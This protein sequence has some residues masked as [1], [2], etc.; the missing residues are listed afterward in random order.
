MR[1]KIEWQWEILDENPASAT[2][3][4]KV[5]GGW[6]LVHQTYYDLGTQKARLC[7]SMTFIA[8]RD[9]EWHVIPALQEVKPNVIAADFEPKAFK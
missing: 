7:E 5:I 3:R 4:A 1:K 8:D 9:H 6:V 2:K